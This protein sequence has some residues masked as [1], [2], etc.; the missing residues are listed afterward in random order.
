M[1]TNCFLWATPKKE[2]VSVKVYVEFSGSFI[3]IHYLEMT[4]SFFRDDQTNRDI[5]NE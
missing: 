4:S 3:F 5:P 2:A 1:L